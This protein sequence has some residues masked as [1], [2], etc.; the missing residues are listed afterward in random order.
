LAR[1]TK[2]INKNINI[3]NINSWVDFGTGDGKVVKT[4]KWNNCEEKIAIDKYRGNNVLDSSWKWQD[5]IWGVTGEKDL[6]TMFDVI[7]HLKKDMGY[8]FIKKAKNKFK[9]IIIFTP[10]GFLIQ[11]ETT[12]PEE[13]KENPWM[14]HLSGWSEEDFRKINFE[15]TVLKDFHYP[16][17]VNK[18]WDA[19]IAVWRRNVHKS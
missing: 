3:E 12:H 4:L 7:E 11:D 13:I 14:K 1:I 2:I 9:N 16:K 17:G 6:L 19:I 8:E 15:V 18:R 10:K 5:D